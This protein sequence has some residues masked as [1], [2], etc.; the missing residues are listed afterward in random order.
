MTSTINWR[1]TGSDA[2]LIKSKG[3]AC[4]PHRHFFLRIG[5]AMIYRML[6]FIPSSIPL[7]KH[8]RL[9]GWPH[10]VPGLEGEMCGAIPSSRLFF[11]S[12]LTLFSPAILT[13]ILG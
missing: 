4:T 5:P 8:S 7:K 6:H 11:R 9:D 3:I 2:G 12:R 1:L 13:T 10:I